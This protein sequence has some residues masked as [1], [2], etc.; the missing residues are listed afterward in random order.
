[1]RA[2]IVLV[3]LLAGCSKSTC[4][5]AVDQMIKCKLVVG[6]LLPGK[7]PEVFL[8][9]AHGRLKGACDVAVESD[10]PDKKRMECAAKASSCDELMACQ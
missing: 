2:A 9:D 6:D 5:K 4:E 10:G 1:M 8:D 3:W 7:G